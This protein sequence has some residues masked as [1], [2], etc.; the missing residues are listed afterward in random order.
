MATQIE[1][2]PSLS[3]PSIVA[4]E[5]GWRRMIADWLAVGGAT[6]VGQALGVVTSLL[7]RTLLDPAQMGVW[8]TLKMVLGYGNYANLGI[9][10]GA[11]R[12][13]TIA[14]G[15]GDLHAA[16]RGL[17]LA[18]T[19]NTLS[20]LVFAAIL[21]GAGAWIGAT[22]GSQWAGT[23]AV[24]LAV[25]GGLAVLDRYASFQVTILRARQAFT[26]TAWLSILE[27][28]LTLGFGGLATWAFG[29]PGLY[30][31]TLAVLAGSL[32]FLRYCRQTDFHWAWQLTEIRRLTAIGSPILLTGVCTTV[33][34]SL[35]K[36]M[37]LAYLNDREFQLGCY[38]VALLVTG[39]LYGLGNMLSTV[40]GPRFGEKFGR[41]GQLR[42]VAFLAARASELQAAALALPAALAIVAAP[43]LLARILPEYQT[44]LAPV[45]WLVPGAVA[46]SL[47][48]AGNQYLIAVDRQRRALAAVLAALGVT[49]LGNHLALR[50]GYGLVG[51]AAAT[52][53][54][55]GF[56]FALVT[57]VSFWLELDGRQRVR[58]VLMHLL[59]IVPAVGSAIALELLLPTVGTDWRL[60]VLKAAAV[61]AVWSLCLAVGWRFGGWG[62]ELSRKGAKEIDRP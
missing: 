29:L 57:A 4:P 12:E 24:G 10:K 1:T 19:V 31:G 54:G 45:I 35:D 37:I 59:A 50:G 61:G 5:T 43:P 21:V 46:M 44:G 14:L 28:V 16:R 30:V 17:D 55:Y 60:L 53:A 13:L 58:Y 25:V 48:L 20:S 15:R 9:S 3:S 42:S 7:F 62:T 8:Q 47:A 11:A 49:A 22:S 27:A 26:A 18:F 36:L 32:V 39:Q 52:A 56:Y 34:C 51:V 23:W 2:L 33:F 41:S 40:V 38:S 6:A